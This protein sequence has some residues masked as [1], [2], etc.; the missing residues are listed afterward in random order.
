MAENYNRKRREREREK[1]EKREIFLKRK[2]LIKQA[3]L[4]H[5][6]ALYLYTPK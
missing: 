6:N 4:I 3:Q 1:R 5:Y 2:E